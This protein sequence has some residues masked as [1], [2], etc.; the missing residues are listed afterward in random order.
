VIAKCPHKASTNNLPIIADNPGT[1]ESVVHRFEKI[2][3]IG[4]RLA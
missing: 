1:L 3:A 4:Q 2:V